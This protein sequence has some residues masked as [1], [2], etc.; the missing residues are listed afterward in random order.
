MEVKITESLSYAAKVICIAS[1]CASI[2]NVLSPG[3]AMKKSFKY[4]LSIFILCAVITPVMNIK[5]DLSQI[6]GTVSSGTADNLSSDLNEITREQFEKEMISLIDGQLKA[7]EIQDA[8]IRLFTDI[9]TDMC[10]YIKKTEIYVDKK[11]SSK[12]KNAEISIRNNIGID[13]NIYLTQEPT[14]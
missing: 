7:S 12:I 11:Y 3:G 10:I 14:G 9:D 13:A 8:E 4:A 5:L 1:L 6:T 2:L